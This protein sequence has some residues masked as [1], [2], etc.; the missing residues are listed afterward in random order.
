[1]VMKKGLA[2]NFFCLICFAQVA[3]SQVITGTFTDSTS[4]P[5]EY[6]KVV[7]FADGTIAGGAFTDSLGG[8][9]IL[10]PS[11]GSY[12]LLVEAANGDTVY[13]RDGIVVGDRI[14]L[15]VIVLKVNGFQTDDVLITARK[16][17]IVRKADRVIFNVENS[18]TS[19]GGTA[20]DALKITPGIRVRQSTIEMI[21]RSSVLIYLDG[22]PLKLSG[23]DLF[24][25]LMSIPASDIKRIEVISN[26][27]A[28]YE[29]QGNSGVVDIVSK[30]T[31][32]RG[33]NGTV[34]FSGVQAFYPGA[35]MGGSLNYSSKKFLVYGGFN[36]GDGNI[37][38]QGRKEVVYPDQVWTEV[39]RSKTGQ[40]YLNGRFGMDYIPSERSRVG[41][42]YWGGTKKPR[43]FESLET[44]VV[45]KA[46]GSIDSML[47]TN[48]NVLSQVNDHYVNGY[49]Q[50]K[51][52]TSERLMML[53]VDFFQYGNNSTQTFSTNT[54]GEGA[55]FLDFNSYQNGVIQG[56]LSGSSSLDFDLPMDFFE[57][58]T[59]AKVSFIKN[60]SSINSFNLTSGEPVIDLTQTS[61]FQ[62]TENTQALYASA[63]KEVGDFELQFGL[64]A[65]YTQT[66]GISKTT[67]T[68]AENEYLK[69][70]PT[71]YLAYAPNDNH[72]FDLTYG[73]RIDRPAYWRLNPFR[74]FNSIYSYTE[75]NPF[76]Q[77]SFYG[78]LEF[79]YAFKDALTFG[80]FYTQGTQ[81]FNEITF[82][83][84][85]NSLQ[86]TTQQNFLTTHSTGFSVSYFFA[87]GSFW[88]SSNDVTVYYNRS[89]SDNPA[90]ARQ[91]EGTTAYASTR[92]TF[93]FN[94]ENTFSGELSYYYQFPEVDGIDIFKSYSGLSAGL[95]WKFFSRKLSVSCQ[96]VDMLA[97]QQYTFSNNINGVKQTSTRYWDT[98]QFIVGL[99]YSFGNAGDL[100]PKNTS[101]NSDEKNR[102]NQ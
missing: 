11:V 86:I 57:F 6:F 40:S 71:A 92:N 100:K 87:V 17:L 10:L 34:R 5:L 32:K 8:F 55:L 80:M 67:N 85:E 22:R 16:K 81:G 36:F 90:T 15:G 102:L 2:V 88:E 99:N 82:V 50:L 47:S 60:N 37:S 12:D 23:Q 66:R 41:V 13:K 61:E 3:W 51:L 18:I 65:E 27:P 7:S 4:I 53:N 38:P 96:M 93:A 77:P 54:Y 44:Q 63:E 46:N 94:K 21:G 83:S 101:S 73:R 52:D 68:F 89:L 98:R 45:A 25:F 29:A 95:Q 69:V 20:L 30:A 26:P 91:V 33:L 14:D 74:R 97:S 62:Y 24:N 59:G 56:I 76:L 78:N 72:F 70:F 49:Y 75:G 19:T 35:S 48:S 1:M 64:R 58:K 9:T 79:T 84:P 43:I 28:N 39:M 42:R 31:S